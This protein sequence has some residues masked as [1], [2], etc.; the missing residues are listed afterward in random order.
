M[1]ENKKS[2][3]VYI[4]SVSVVTLVVLF[5]LVFPA[6][7]EMTANVL[8]KVIVRNF[9]WF[10]TL[11]MTSF[12][13]FAVWI[14]YFSRYKDMKLGP[15]DSKPEYSNISWFAMLFS[16]GMG[17][18]L[19]FYGIYEPLYHYINPIAQEPMS[20]NAARFAMTKSYLHWGLHPWANYS[21]LGLG[22]A[23]MQFRKNK[24]GLI[25]TLFIPLIGEE[26]VKGAIGKTIDVLAIFATAAG[27]ATS[28]GLGT[29]QINSGLK[30]IFGIPETTLVQIIIVVGITIVYTWTAVTGID[31]GIKLI[32]N[33]NMI[34][35]V[36]L[37]GLAI[38]FGP[39]VDILNIFG[40]SLGDYLQTLLANTFE[41]GAFDK[42][43]WHG[44]WTIFYW[45][46]WIAWA[47]FTGTFIARISRGR[48]IKEFIS[49]VLIVPSL[50]SFFWFSIFGA[51]D[52]S[53]EKSVLLEAVKSASTAFFTVMS[54]I[55]FG[56]VMSVIAIALLFTF[57][58]TSANSATF[59]LGMLSDEGNLDPPNSKKLVWGI[60]Q[61][62]LALSLMVGSKNGLG[63]L[64]TISIVAAFPFIFIMLLTMVS[65]VKAL[66]EEPGYN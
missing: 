29:Y 12:I 30:F 5:G 36:A 33:L 20:A 14:A 64:Q 25:S 54:N 22:L 23:Y 6:G 17:I 16:A 53:V 61:S 51:I 60:V 32:S 46:W 21:I 63:M 13:V 11:A 18:G 44:A 49:G 38:I 34:L 28:L 31:K 45:A 62:A 19:V 41:I 58:I 8:L 43:D 7:F 59:V 66:K 57:F 35:V 37:L 40:E 2:N 9:G 65:L 15:E 39:T 55:T 3:S 10:Y 42:G 26:K 24:P 4:I 47:P 48:T 50:V 52:F 27:M 56:N 1:G